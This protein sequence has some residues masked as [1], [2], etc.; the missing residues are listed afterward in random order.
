MMGHY[1][2]ACS[3]T[4]LPITGGT[5]VRCLLLTTSPY[6][7]DWIVRTPPLHAVYDGYGSIERV[8]EDDAFVAD[9]W[10]R[11]FRED[12]V[13]KGLGDNSYHDVPTSRD[14]T[15]GEMLDA[16]RAGRVTVHQDARH[17]WYRSRRSE[18]V[19]PW[20]R[21]VEDVVR[22]A[23]PVS[24]HA[25]RD[26]YVVDEPVPNVARVR[27]GEY[28]RGPEHAAALERAREAVEAAGF[29]GV[30]AQGSGRYP[31][32]ADLVVMA[33]PG[34]ERRRGAQWDMSPGGA[35][36]DDKKLPVRVAMVRED[37]W[38][39]L[40]A[41]PRSESVSTACANCGQSSWYH[42]KDREC[43][44][45]SYNGV[46]LKKYPP[47]ACYAHGPL[48]TDGVEHVVVPRDWGEDVWYALG[49][50]RY[51]VREAWASI[52]AHFDELGRPKSSAFGDYLVTDFVLPHSR[53][54]PGAWI[55]HRGVPVV[56]GISEHLSMCLADRKDV[57][58]CVLDGVAELAAVTCSM[59]DVG[60]S[61]AP[62]TSAGPQD[63]EWADHV[64]FAK[65][66]ARLAGDRVGDGVDLPTTIEQVL[67][68]GDGEDSAR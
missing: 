31:D 20:F 67:G 62:S 5:P 45:R 11:G 17:F 30:V 42:G 44:D 55:L 8:H 10:L 6:D 61:W 25:A 49:A 28:Q 65:T 9:L 12:L 2:M 14:W 52:L 59:R 37:A 50:F 3:A 21:C 58:E 60:R 56:V 35:A 54:F 24:R 27:F 7:E 33:A 64:R 36:D 26:R 15:F 63:P 48:F 53:D 46:P 39:A 34:D 19:T 32:E 68:M 4:G 38:R 1:A 22:A 51:G 13:E 41:Y 16:L 29:V 23:G 47:G 57:P 40:A 66:I 43:P 18:G